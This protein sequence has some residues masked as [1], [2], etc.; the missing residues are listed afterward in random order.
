MAQFKLRNHNLP[1]KQTGGDTKVVSIRQPS[2]NP[3]AYLLTRARCLLSFALAL[4]RDCSVCDS[5]SFMRIPFLPP[6]PLMKPLAVVVGMALNSICDKG[7][8]LVSV[9]IVVVVVADIA[10]TLEEEKGPFLDDA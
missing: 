3:H 5:A 6:A 1:K 10:A 4:F 9:A 7:N 8:P 2:H